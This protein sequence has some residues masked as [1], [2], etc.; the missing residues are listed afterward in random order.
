MIARIAILTAAAVSVAAAASADIAITW[1]STT[2]QDK[3]SATETVVETIR[4]DRQREDHEGIVGA[5]ERGYS[6]IRDLATRH[7]YTLWHSFKQY[8][9]ATLRA[10]TDAEKKA[11]QGQGPQRSGF[12]KRG[13]EVAAVAG[14]GE[15]RTIAGLTCSAYDVTAKAADSRVALTGTYWVAVTG[16]GVA[17][18]QRFHRKLRDFTSRDEPEPQAVKRGREDVWGVRDVRDAFMRAALDAGFPC[19]V[20]YEISGLNRVFRFTRE[21]V[22]VSAARVPAAALSVPADYKRT[23]QR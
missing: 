14:R 21:A 22:K 11:A 12:A 4:A 19:L 1:K 2:T 16:E 18:Y 13:V 6:F 23:V 17:D 10:R 15:Q 7:Q 3:T 9:E 5:F 20:E 8:R